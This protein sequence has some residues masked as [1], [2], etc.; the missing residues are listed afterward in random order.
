MFCWPSMI[1]LLLRAKFG[2]ILGGEDGSEADLKKLDWFPKT[3]Q[4]IGGGIYRPICNWTWSADMDKAA[5]TGS[6][7]V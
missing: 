7:Q 2:K 3:A 4:R 5:D 6:F 1:R